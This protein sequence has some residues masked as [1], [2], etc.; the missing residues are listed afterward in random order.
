MISLNY[1]YFLLILTMLTL[2]ACG[3]TWFGEKEEPPLPGERISVL[4]LQNSLEAGDVALTA[5]GFIVSD[6]WENQFWPQKGGYANHNMQNL[7]LNT[8]ALKKAWSADIGDGN[9]DRLPL[10]SQPIVANGM[11]FTLDSKSHL[12][13]MNAKTGKQIWQ[14]NLKPSKEDYVIGGGLAYGEDMLFATTGRD[15]VYALNPENGEPYWRVRIISPARAAPTVLDGKL[16]ITTLDNRLLTMDT[17]TG[18]V[19]W[20][21]Q[22]LAETSALL[23][24][25]SPA[26]N[27]NVVLTAYSSGEIFALRPENGS[28]AWFDN[29][30]SVRNVTNLSKISDIRALPVLDRGLVVAVSYG[31]Q[32]VAID[33]RTGERIWQR[34][35][36][37]AET[38][39]IAGNLIFVITA[40][41]KMVAL[42]RDS[43]T[44]AWITPLREFENQKDNIGAVSWTAPVLAGGRLILFN[45][46]G[47]AAEIN[48]ENGELIRN[49]EIKSGVSIAPIVAGGMLYVLADNGTI[50]AY[51]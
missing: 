4:E 31:G 11:L 28:V 16:Y 48:P 40:D 19:L 37:S 5:Q 45:S 7:V 20:D 18:S 9:T 10:T 6:A 25:A 24:G 44:Y 29:L 43:G 39:W 34:D 30:T 17:K 41:N 27:S 46:L 47:E 13:A 38:P 35:L 21:H 36:S 15:D 49:W 42:G 22:G 12:K 1:R 26:A 23:G 51:E 32:M 8:G 14:R 2:T 50:Y 33:E 3:S